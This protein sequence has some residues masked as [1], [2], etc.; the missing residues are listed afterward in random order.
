[1]PVSSVPGKFSRMTWQQVC[2]D[3]L[4]QDLPYRM[5]LNKWG[6]IVMSRIPPTWH[7]ELISQIGS[8]LHDTQAKGIVSIVTAVDTSEN[9]KVVDVAWISSE[10]R[11]ANPS[12][13]SYAVAPEIC[14]E[15]IT[16]EDFLEDQ[17]HRGELYLQAG[18]EEFWLCDKSGDLRF[19]DT[20]GALERS[21]LCPEFPIKFVVLA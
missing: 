3:P 5:E 16:P 4:L 20:N 10:R 7:G 6:N 19:F 12:E 21:R 11:R 14:V 15:I 17:M 2:D 18:A 8:R 1:M 9:T 13:Y